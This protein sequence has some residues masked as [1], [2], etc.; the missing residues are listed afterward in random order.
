MFYK[1]DMAYQ[2]GVIW[3]LHQIFDGIQLLVEARVE[4]IAVVD[5]VNEN[6]GEDEEV[7]GHIHEDER[8]SEH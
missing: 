3:Y 5:T 8:L 4:F 7:D 1:Q 2:V 6:E